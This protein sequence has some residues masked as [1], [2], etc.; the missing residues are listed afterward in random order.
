MATIG[1]GLPY[2]YIYKYIYKYTIQIVKTNT[3]LQIFLKPL[4]SYISK[5]AEQIWHSQGD[6]W[7]QKYFDP[8]KEIFPLTEE[9]YEGKKLFSESK[10]YF[11]EH[12][13]YFIESKKYYIQ[14]KK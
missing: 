2:K 7:C 13:K 6:T 10:T 8:K 9:L 5:S 14:S 4:T 1:Q 11:M 3:Q 12:K